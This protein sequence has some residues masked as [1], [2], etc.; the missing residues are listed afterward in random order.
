MDE[1]ILNKTM[2]IAEEF[3]GTANDPEQILINLES[4]LKLQRLHKKTFVCQIKNDQ[5]ISWVIVIPTQKKIAEDFLSGQ[6]NER[7][8]LD[9]SQP[10]EKFEALYFC[11]AF[12]VPKHRGN[13]YSSE[14]FQEAVREISLVDEAIFFAW[15][16]SE[17]GK[18]LVEKL[19][20]IFGRKFRIK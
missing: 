8:L 2:A 20:D 3:F 4:F 1:I 16:T 7:Q 18:H 10:Q 15:P 19:E 11:S 13:N 6:I 14:L 12:T 9:F 5:P 17:E